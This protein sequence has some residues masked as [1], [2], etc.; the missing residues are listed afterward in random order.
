MG[1]IFVC[2]AMVKKDGGYIQRD[3]EASPARETGSHTVTLAEP[4]ITE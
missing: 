4:V 3:L 2:I 1:N